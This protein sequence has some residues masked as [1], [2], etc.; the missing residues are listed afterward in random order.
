VATN[1]GNVTLHGVTVTDAQV[2]DLVCSPVTPVANL[3]PGGSI[4]CTAS[5][6]ITQTDLNA[7]SFYNQACV[8]D[9]AG[10]AAQACDDVTT[11][12]TPPTV[13]SQITPTATSCSDFNSGTAATLGQLDYS[14]KSGKVGS[15]SP[16]VFFYW[17]EVTATAG[18]NTFVIDQ[19]I[20]SANN[21]FNHFFDIASGSFVWDSSCNKVGT[22]RITQ[23]NGTQ[24]D[25]ATI[26]F[27]APSAGTYIIG[28]KYDSGSVGG[29]TAPTTN[30]QV[31]YTFTTV[32]VPASIQGIDLVKK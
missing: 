2:T 25:K 15:V 28:V 5:H 18:S 19:D 11:P 8:D 7:G 22:Q 16:G 27:T 24:S 32:G 10:G 31:H 17:I 9:G 1:D 23:G 21:N 30:T 3:A 29:K 6:T 20:T 26:V 14:V 13:V 4:S 12:G